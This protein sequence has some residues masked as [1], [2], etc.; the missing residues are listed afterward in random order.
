MGKYSDY[1]RQPSLNEREANSKLHPIWQG[2]GFGLMIL[3]PVLGCFGALA[4]LDENARRGW[5]TI[6][7]DLLAPGNDPLLYVKIILT[8][9]LML[10]I[11]TFFQL[12]TYVLYRLFGPSRY[13]PLDVPPVAY[14][15]RRKRQR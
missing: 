4:L 7:A 3:T 1:K 11:F 8:I 6:P 15:K 10:V 14:P 13:G 12:I 9:A 2:V 5:V